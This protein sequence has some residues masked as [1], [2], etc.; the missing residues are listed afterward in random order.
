MS[1]LQLI[2][3]LHSSIPAWLYVQAIICLCKNA[4][5]GMRI[6]AAYLLAFECMQLKV[7]SLQPLEMH[8]SFV[9]PY[10]IKK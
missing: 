3:Q 8:A 5:V 1:S 7:G 10:A 9:L 6:G 2:T 4:G